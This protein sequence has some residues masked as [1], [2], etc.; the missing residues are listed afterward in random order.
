MSADDM[1]TAMVGI[2]A[3]I[4]LDIPESQK[5]V[6]IGIKS[7]GVPMA[8][9]VARILKE[10]FTR[11]MPVGVL[12]INLYRDDLSEVGKDPVVKPVQIPFDITGTHVILFDDVL[13]TGRTIRAAMDALIDH[14]RPKTIRL[15]VM[16]DRG[17][18]EFPIQADYVGKRIQTTL[19]QNVK[20]CFTETDGKTEVYIKET[21]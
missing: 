11:Q 21:R 13:Y 8:A 18:R 1:K 6:L 20:V 7:R 9:A 10:T 4:C 2:A 15:A 3:A 19:S 12:D 17:F 14:G 16:V 5:A